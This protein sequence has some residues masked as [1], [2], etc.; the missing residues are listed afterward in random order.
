MV[1]GPFGDGQLTK[2]YST[3]TFSPTSRPKRNL[4][5]Y[6]YICINIFYYLTYQLLIFLDELN[7]ND[8]SNITTKRQRGLFHNEPDLLFNDFPLDNNI[9]NEPSQNSYNADYNNNNKN[10]NSNNNN[11]NNN[12]N[13]NS[14][15]NNQNNN[16]NINKSNLCLTDEDGWID[17]NQQRS[18]HHSNCD[19]HI[20]YDQHL[21]QNLN[22]IKNENQRLKSIINFD[23]ENSIKQPAIFVDNY[24]KPVV[25]EVKFEIKPFNPIPFSNSTT[26]TTTYLRDQR[27]FKKNS[28]CR[29]INPDEPQESQREI[30]R[31]RKSD[32]DKVL[33]K[34][35]EREMTVRK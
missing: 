31:L 26:T 19:N 6:L 20:G 14:N 10:N 9:K 13:N 5:K 34:E 12:Q 24:P 32:M 2:N 17:V 3:T 8:E 15:Y 25:I 28:I 27:R 30:I 23:E 7:H 16:E 22:Q 21:N 1:K 29:R 18:S 33:P 35:S 11:N 4:G